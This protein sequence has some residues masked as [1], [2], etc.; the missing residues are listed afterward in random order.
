MQGENDE[1]VWG[2]TG[3]FVMSSFY[4]SAV[5]SRWM[6]IYKVEKLL[7]VERVEIVSKPG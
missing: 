5:E 4:D 1:L 2:R 3:V 6:V 7:R